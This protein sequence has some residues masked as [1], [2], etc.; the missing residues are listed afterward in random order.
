MKG[1]SSDVGVFE[2]FAYIFPQNTGV[3]VF[4]LIHLLYPSLS[5]STATTSPQTY[6]TSSRISAE[7]NTEQSFVDHAK[8]QAQYELSQLG[9]N[10]WAG[11]KMKGGTKKDYVNSATALTQ[12][13][14]K[15]IKTGGYETN[16]PFRS[17]LLADLN[18]KLL[19]DNSAVTLGMRKRHEDVA[20]FVTVYGVSPK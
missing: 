8:A 1:E 13:D 5:W 15:T 14:L 3:V 11:L 7:M 20:H 4:P 2:S 12:D 18:S 16:T 6:P 10:F 19:A 9:D 17:S